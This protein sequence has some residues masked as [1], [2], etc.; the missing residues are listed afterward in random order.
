[1]VNPV[2]HCVDKADKDNAGLQI[3]L[4]SQCSHQSTEIVNKWIEPVWAKQHLQTVHV[5][6]LEPVVCVLLLVHVHV[7]VG[8]DI[9]G[10]TEAF[11]CFNNYILH[12]G[13]DLYTCQ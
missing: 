7:H 6:G 5:E 12:V 11:K 1:M 9:L 10:C 3:N 8:S 4:T 2:Q 13:R